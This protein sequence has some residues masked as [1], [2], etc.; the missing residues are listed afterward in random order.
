M[1]ERPEVV[2][3]DGS[4]V[5]ASDRENPDLFWA[6]RGRAGGN[7]G[8][9]TAFTF[10]AVSVADQVA[11]VFD[12]GFALETGDKLMAALQEIIDRDQAA[13]FDCRGGFTN[14]GTGQ[15]EIALL[16]PVPGD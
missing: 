16:G 2:P 6:C 14:P 12:S 3:A 9:N 15:G 5:R 7:F 13:D 8:I 4:L 11:T 10:D 1:G